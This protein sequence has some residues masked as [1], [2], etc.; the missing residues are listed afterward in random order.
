MRLPLLLAMFI[1]GCSLSPVSKDIKVQHE[2]AHCQRDKIEHLLQPGDIIF[3]QGNAMVAGGTINFSQ[4]VAQ[5]SDSD[6]SH[7]VIVY[8]IIDGEA[9]IPDVS[10]QGLQRYF[11]IDWLMDGQDNVVVKRVKPEYRHFIPH[12][13]AEVEKLIDKDP[14]Y[15]PTF[16][17]EDDRFYCIE[18]VD[19]CFREAGLPLAD[20]IAIN[21]LP[22]YNEVWFLVVCT[23]L[24]LDIDTNDKVVVAG[25]DEIGLFSSP[26]LE[27]VIDLRHVD[28]QDD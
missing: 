10:V 5:V 11:L 19:Y 15:D 8:N 2:R 25:N 18:A 9:V 22:G 3:R 28:N 20:R 26:Y 17:E 16:K 7:A 13:L 1:C 24:F 6:F 23:Q 21:E 12:V 14:L 4:L 27:T